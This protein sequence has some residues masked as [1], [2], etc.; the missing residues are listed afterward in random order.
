MDRQTRDKMCSCSR[1]VLTYSPCQHDGVVPVKL[2]VEKGMYFLAI[3]PPRNSR[4][5][6]LECECAEVEI[7]ILRFFD[8][9]SSEG[10]D[11]VDL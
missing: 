4:L 1:R 2:Y 8:R 9:I 6:V 11:F 3:K 5:Q 7:F 10:I